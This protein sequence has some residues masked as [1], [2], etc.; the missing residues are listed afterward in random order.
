MV[1]LSHCNCSTRCTTGTDQ[2]GK[3]IKKHQN[4]CKKSDTGQGSRAD[5]RDMSDINSVYDIIEQVDD[6]CDNGR[7]RQLRQ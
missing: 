5:P 4:R 6:L 1:F 2:H 3:C 7:D